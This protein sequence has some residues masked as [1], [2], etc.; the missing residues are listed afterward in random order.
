M[1]SAFPT[2]SLGGPQYTKWTDG[3]P[4]YPVD[5]YT[6][7]DGSVDALLWSDEPTLPWDIEYEGLTAAEAEVLDNHRASAMGEFDTFDL[8]HPRTGVTYNNVRY[9]TYKRDHSRTWI[10]T[11]TVTLIQTPS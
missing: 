1:P 8:I 5:T 2:P 10:E 4:I 7:Q 11:R 6:Y 9:K 3:D